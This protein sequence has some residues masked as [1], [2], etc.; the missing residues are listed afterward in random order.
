MASKFKLVKV[1]GDHLGGLTV[2][3]EP[4]ERA[5]DGSFSIP[6]FYVTEVCQAFGLSTTKPGKVTDEGA[7]Q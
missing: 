3:G 7:A 6:E 5:K 1:W 2:E 4:V